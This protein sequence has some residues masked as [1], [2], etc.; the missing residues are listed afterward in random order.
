MLRQIIPMIICGSI[1][2]I[3]IPV[4]VGVLHLE[5]NSSAAILL[6]TGIISGFLSKRLLTRK[7]VKRS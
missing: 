4:C 3:G 1:V 6:A 5:L 2:V 7:N